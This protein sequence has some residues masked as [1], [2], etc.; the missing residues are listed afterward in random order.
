MRAVQTTPA[1]WE[2]IY[3]EARIAKRSSI[4]GWAREALMEKLA[5]SGQQVPVDDPFGCLPLGERKFLL[6][7]A[8]FLKEAH[9]TP[10]GESLMRA[11]DGLHRLFEWWAGAPVGAKEWRE[12]SAG[13]S[14]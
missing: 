11:G 1:V 7:M 4:R 2:Q 5:R 14:K 8:K 3:R 13:E 10:F 6:R 12:L 9:G